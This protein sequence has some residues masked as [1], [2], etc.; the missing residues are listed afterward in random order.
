MMFGLTFG[1]LLALAVV[2]L[3]VL[4]L[5]GTGVYKVKQWGANEV[6]AEWD[7]EKR[8]AAERALDAAQAFQGDRSSAQVIYKTIKENTITYIDRPVYSTVCIDDDGLRNINGAL[9]GKGSTNP[10]GVVP[11]AKPADGKDR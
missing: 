4:S 1:K 8:Q 7:S 3:A 5:I 10:S 6:Q 2:V 9:S 11:G